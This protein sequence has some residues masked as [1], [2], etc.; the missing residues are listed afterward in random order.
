MEAVPDVPV[1]PDLGNIKQG[2]THKN[3]RT[4]WF[5]TWNNYSEE[6]V[7][8]LERW[9]SA[10]C[11]KSAIGREVAPT[12]G[13]PH[14]QGHIQLKKKMRWQTLMNIFPFSFLEPTRS[15]EHAMAY[16]QKDGQMISLI[17]VPPPVRDPLAGRVAHPWQEKLLQHLATEPDDRSIIWI[18]EAVGCTGKT[19]LA[20]S[21][22]IK[23]KKEA[24]FLSGK[25]ADI[26]YGVQQFIEGGNTLKIAMFHYT[27]TTEG[28]VSYEALESIKDGIFFSGKYEG[29]MVLYNPPHVV[30]F[31]NF[32]PEQNKL[33]QD[34]WHVF[35]ITEKETPPLADEDLDS[36]LADFY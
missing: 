4:K 24:V 19:T 2:P 18:W 20:K 9:C 8:A 29:G 35:N 3:P 12:T 31:A 14:L 17:G 21:I 1:V 15:D 13:T 30:V 10:N 25:G 22:C 27:R 7:V 36:V 32:P 23:H 33:S 11:S 34:R 28:F 6:N 5:F 16:C 26:K